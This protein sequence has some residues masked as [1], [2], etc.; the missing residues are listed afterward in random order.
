[1]INKLIYLFIIIIF[2]YSCEPKKD[3]KVIVS[4]KSFGFSES[5]HY[6]A[7]VTL[8]N[9]GE[10]PA[11]FVILIASAHSGEKE[12][13]RIERGYGDIFPNSTKSNRLIFD[14]YRL[15]TP[16]TVKF[17]IT[18]SHSISYSISPLSHDW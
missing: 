6:F 11:Y 18:F 9:V 4:E 7:D 14:K 8:K 2:I 5:G 3:P 1:M 10:I 17:E 13:Q 15:S 12:I 16:D